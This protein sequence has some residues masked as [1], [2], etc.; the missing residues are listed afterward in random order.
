MEY[1]KIETLY[2]RD[3]QTHRLK[4]RPPTEVKGRVMLKPRN[5]EAGFYWVR[6]SWGWEPAGFDGDDWLR[7]GTERAWNDDVE[8]VGC[9]IQMPDG[10]L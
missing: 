7:I 8:E 1:H 2:E 3:E 5:N 4:L 6:F 10:K 9:V